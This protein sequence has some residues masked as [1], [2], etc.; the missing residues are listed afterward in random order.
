MAYAGSRLLYV[1]VIMKMFTKNIPE[2][3]AFIF[4]M[5]KALSWLE[6]VVCSVMF[7]KE[8]CHKWLIRWFFSL[9][10]PKQNCLLDLFPCPS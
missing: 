8:R 10:A 7:S 6:I 3:C 5:I 1:T 4:S 9:Q 2:V